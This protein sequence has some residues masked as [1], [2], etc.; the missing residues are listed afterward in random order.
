MDTAMIQEPW[1]T[2]GR[3]IGLNIP[4]YILFCFSGIDRPKACI[5][6][7]NMNIWRLAG[8]SSRDLLAVLLN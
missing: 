1:Y 4:E 3:V 5:L 6:A 2:E 8:F 7:T